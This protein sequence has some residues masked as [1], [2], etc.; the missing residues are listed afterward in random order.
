MLGITSPVVKVEMVLSA[1]TWNSP[2]HDLFTVDYLHQGETKIWYSVPSS[3]K[4]KLFE[5][6]KQQLNGEIGDITNH[7]VSI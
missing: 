3:D 2:P 5:V 6:M 4:E 7:L 1:E